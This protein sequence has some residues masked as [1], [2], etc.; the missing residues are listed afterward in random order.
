M[1]SFGIASFSLQGLIVRGYRG[2]FAIYV[3]VGGGKLKFGLGRMSLIGQKRPKLPWLPAAKST[4]EQR[5]KFVPISGPS[6]SHDASRFSEM[7]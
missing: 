1:P 6:T 3:S 5:V 7:N 4:A 2:R